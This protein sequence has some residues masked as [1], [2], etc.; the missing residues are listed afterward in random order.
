M[1]ATLTCYSPVQHECFMTTNNALNHFAAF[2]G[3]TSWLWAEGK[4]W[5]RSLKADKRE[6]KCGYSGKHEE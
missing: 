2:K 4:A 3:L 1:S 6:V 5:L